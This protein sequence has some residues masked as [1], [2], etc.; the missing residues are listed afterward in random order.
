MKTGSPWGPI[1]TVLAKED[2][3]LPEYHRLTSEQP[4]PGLTSPVRGSS[5]LEISLNVK[6][7]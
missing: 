4:N 1:L 2:P 3:W 7:D 5:I 6:E